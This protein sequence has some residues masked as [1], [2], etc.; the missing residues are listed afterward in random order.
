MP[1]GRFDSK[2]ERE[3]YGLTQKEYEEVRTLVHKLEKIIGVPKNPLFET[4]YPHTA[5]HLG[6]LERALMFLEHALGGKFNW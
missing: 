4:K 3:L 1:F 6:K 2:M 5:E